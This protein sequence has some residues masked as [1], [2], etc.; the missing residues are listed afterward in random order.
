MATLANAFA[1]RGLGVDLVLARAEGPYLERLRHDVRVIDLK[2]RRVA[3]SLPGLVRYLRREQPAAMLSAA[4]HANVIAIVARILARL[5]MRLVVSERALIF[6]DRAASGK[7][8]FVTSAMQLCYP[9]ADHVIAVS[10]GVATALARMI[11]LAD[12]QLS[13]I[14]NPLDMSAIETLSAERPKHPFLADGLP[15][16]IAVGR[17]DEIKGHDVLLRAISLI[18][19]R[20]PLRVLVV[21]EGP[22]KTT[23]Q[24]LARELGIHHIVDFIGFQTNPFAWM[25]AADVFV[26]SSRSDAMP[27]AMLQAMACGLR[28]V[29]TDCGGPAEILENGRWGRLV[30]VDA[31]AAMARAIT[32]ALADTAP[33]DVRAR[34]RSFDVDAIADAYLK[35]MGVEA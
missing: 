26:L 25:A 19:P 14:H 4:S 28:I 12:H 5:P 16:I 1:A 22:R 30:A 27:N 17:L 34:A 29:S 6:S 13:V 10:S 35:V 15:T 31:P 32:E 21:G 11:R 8:A 23:L 24:Q 33:P 7:I 18:D 20:V 2:S 3:S 9:R